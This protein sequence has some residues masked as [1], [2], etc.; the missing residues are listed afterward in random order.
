MAQKTKRDLLHVAPNN[1]HD[2]RSCFSASKKFPKLT[3]RFIIVQSLSIAC[4]KINS[5][6]TK[7][8]M[9]FSRSNGTNY[10]KKIHFLVDIILFIASEKAKYN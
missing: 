5:Q 8:I 3:I 6:K 9:K 7:N 10:R 2:F 4:W 1:F